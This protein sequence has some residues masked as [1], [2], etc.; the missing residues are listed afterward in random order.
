MES[1]Q[2]ELPPI[3]WPCCG[4]LIAGTLGAGHHDAWAA[5]AVFAAIILL[6]AVTARSAGA[7]TVAVTLIALSAAL[8]R[9]MPPTQQVV[10]WPAENVNAVR[11]TV[12]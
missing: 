4:V 5:V 2:G 10:I 6:L 1:G 12:V 8:F 7:G 9:S 3:L 11:A